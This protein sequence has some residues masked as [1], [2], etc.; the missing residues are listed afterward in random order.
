MGPSPIGILYVHKRAI[1][2]ECLIDP[3]FVTV[4][5]TCTHI[6]LGLCYEIRSNDIALAWYPNAIIV[7]VQQSMSRKAVSLNQILIV[8]RRYCNSLC[9]V[10]H[11]HDDYAVFYLDDYECITYY[12]L[13][14][15]CVRTQAE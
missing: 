2:R 13:S 1:L 5:A 6:D 8:T 14:I 7:M 9:F 3:C 4:W 10:A 11:C 15:L 12:W